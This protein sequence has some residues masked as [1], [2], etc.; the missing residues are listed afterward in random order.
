MEATGESAASGGSP[1]RARVIPREVSDSGDGVILPRMLFA[2]MLPIFLSPP[3]ISAQQAPHTGEAVVV[4]S[5][6]GQ[7]IP[8]KLLAGAFY[9]PL[10]G[11]GSKP[12]E[13]VYRLKAP[14]G[15]FVPPHWHG[16]TLH[17]SVLSG[18]LM[19]VM[20][21]PFDSSR[22][23]APGRQLSGHAGPHGAYRIVRG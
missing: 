7:W 8:T 16:Q 14:N 10:V 3:E 13:Y 23:A 11:Q 12:E 9:L 4:P 22:A 21:A 2:I 19:A 15:A 5:G 18:T 6:K 17:I 20:G 1:T